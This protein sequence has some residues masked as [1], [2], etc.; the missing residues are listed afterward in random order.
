[1]WVDSLESEKEKPGR[2]EKVHLSLTYFSKA[3]AEFFLA[4]HLFSS[5]LCLTM[6]WS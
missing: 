4:A 2:G 5:L 1:M 3:K 6:Q